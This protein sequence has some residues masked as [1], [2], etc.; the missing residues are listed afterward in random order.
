MRLW[1]IA[2][3]PY[4]PDAQFKSFIG[5]QSNELSQRRTGFI[6]YKIFS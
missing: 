5:E 4:L 3:L 2:L 1:H 6:F